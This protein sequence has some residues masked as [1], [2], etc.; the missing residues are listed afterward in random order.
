V[1]AGRHGLP[2]HRP[3]RVRPRSE[4]SDRLPRHTGATGSVT[5]CLES[6]PGRRLRARPRLWRRRLSGVRRDR[7]AGQNKAGEVLV[8]HHMRRALTRRQLELTEEV[9]GPPRRRWNAVLRPGAGGR[10]R[11]HPTAGACWLLAQG[12]DEVASQE[13]NLDPTDH[14]RVHNAVVRVRRKQDRSIRTTGSHDSHRDTVTACRSVDQQPGSDR[15]PGLSDR[16]LKRIEAVRML[17]GRPEN[18]RSSRRRHP[19]VNPPHRS[20]SSWAYTT[21]HL[22]ERVNDARILTP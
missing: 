11:R 6:R 13:A 12:E 5:D 18:A 17:D 8:G 2:G 21:G 10:G 16:V 20:R 9:T 7:L 3:K 1:S 19:G 4:R 22:R 14:R 15:L